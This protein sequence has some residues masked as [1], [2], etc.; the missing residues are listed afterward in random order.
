MNQV[1]TARFGSSTLVP[2][3]FGLAGEARHGPARHGEARP[4]VAWQ[5]AAGR[6]SSP[7]SSNARGGRK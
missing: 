6:L 3:G 4:G 7:E 2:A 1:G 5:G